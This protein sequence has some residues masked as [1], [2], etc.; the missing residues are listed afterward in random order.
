VGTAHVDS[1]RTHRLQVQLALEAIAITTG[2]ARGVLRARPARRVPDRSPADAKPRHGG[3]RRREPA[4]VLA[5]AA[6][7]VTAPEKARGRW[8][9]GGAP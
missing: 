9:G 7:A 1:T 4:H 3:G 2:P 5:H 6:G 8:S